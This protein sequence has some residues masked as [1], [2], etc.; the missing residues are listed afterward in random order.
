MLA[1]VKPAIKGNFE[2]ELNTFSE[3]CTKLSSMEFD[4][5]VEKSIGN[6]ELEVTSRNLEALLRGKYVCEGIAEIARNAFILKG[7]NS[8]FIKGYAPQ[9]G[10]AWNQVMIGGNWFNTDLTWYMDDVRYYSKKGILVGPFIL[11]NDAE[12]RAHDVYSGK[13]PKGEEKCTVSLRSY[14]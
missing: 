8:K 6:V 4:N 7:L 9:S 1:D 5:E 13:R 12:F 3:I 14:R 10:H 11:L 2:S